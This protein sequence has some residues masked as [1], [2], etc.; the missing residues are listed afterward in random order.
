MAI[1]SAIDAS[2]V[3]RVVGIQ[4][5]PKNFR[6][7]SVLLLPQRVMLVGQGS[8]ASA[9]PTTKAQ[10]TSAFEVGTNYGFGS[11]IHLA[12]LELFPING[13]GVRSVPVTAY[14]LEDDGSGAATVVEV[15]PTGTATAA[16]IYYV[17]VNGLRSN[18]IVTA[19][20]DTVAS[21]TAAA[22]L[23]V[24]AILNMP[25]T[26]ADG[27]TT[28]DLTAKWKGASGNDIDVQIEGPTD[29]GLT[30]GV[31]QATAGAV[32]PSVSAALAQVGGVWE[33]M[34]LN[35]LDI[36]DTATLDLYQAFGAGQWLPTVNK[37]MMFFTGNTISAVASAIAVPDARATDFINGQLVAPGSRSL[38]FVVA[39]R[40]L[41]RIVLLANNNPPH[42]YGRQSADGILPGTDGEQWKYNQRDLAVKAGSSTIEVRDGVV[43]ISDVVTF[44]H[45]AGDPLPAY[46]FVVDIVKL[47]NIIYN[48]S[49]IFNTAEWDGAPLLPDADP[50]TNASAKKPKMAR[51]AVASMLDSLGLEAIISDPKTAKANTLAEIDSV[52]PKRLNVQIPVQLVG[53][54]NIISVGLDFGFFFGTSAIVA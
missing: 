30:F 23:A 44:Y 53:N 47:Q 1:N 35:C 31:A 36:A 21:F 6:N 14:P 49:L 16:G 10:V 34:G 39:A 51:A 2:A 27:T 18:A 40:Q 41:A 52:N 7:G 38:P 46:R 15:T 50:T 12:A 28:L 48:I 13:D 33:T 25:V 43:D 24:A 29:A 3:A 45:P 22:T 54:S 8:S 5:T 26:A 37:P 42:D 20:G 4:T 32:N 9:Y 11:P 17:N 19:I